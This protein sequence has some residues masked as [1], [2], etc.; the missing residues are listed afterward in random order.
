MFA[1]SFKDLTIFVPY[2]WIK[3]SAFYGHW[4][5]SIQL[6]SFNSRFS[7]GNGFDDYVL[8]LTMVS[9]NLVSVP[10]MHPASHE[11]KEWDSMVRFTYGK[12]EQLK[13][14]DLFL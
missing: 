7:I 14:N 3:M 6:V 4:K 5:G 12:F 10:P 1:L 2:Y 8:F 11:L 13:T 9:W